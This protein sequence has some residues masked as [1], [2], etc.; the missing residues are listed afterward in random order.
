VR[1]RDGLLRAA[2]RRGASCRGLEAGARCVPR[3]HRRRDGDF[4]AIL[5]YAYEV[6]SSPAL[7]LVAFLTLA[8]AAVFAPVGATLGDRFR[9]EVML[10]VACA[11]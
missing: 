7:G 6:G 9:R 8:P 1:R 10:T 11:V 4:I 3:F 5:I 2:P